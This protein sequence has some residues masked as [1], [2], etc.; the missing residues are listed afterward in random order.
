MTAATD[1]AM[2]RAHQAAVDD[3]RRD[4]AEIPPD[5]PGNIIAGSE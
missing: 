3:L 4:Y 2:M 5:L 1:Q